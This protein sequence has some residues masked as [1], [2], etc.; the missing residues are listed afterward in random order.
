M[1]KMT[2]EK[3]NKENKT[4]F[5]VKDMNGEIMEDYIKKVI[6]EKKAIEGMQVENRHKQYSNVQTIKYYKQSIE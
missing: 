6:K 5:L 3:D 2:K 1:K 4:N